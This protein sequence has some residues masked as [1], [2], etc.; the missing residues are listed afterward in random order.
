MSTISD[1]LDGQAAGEP[2]GSGGPSGPEAHDGK[3]YLNASRGVLS[4]LF[5]LDHKR[6]GV[7]STLR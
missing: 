4:W 2:K 6:I 3:N 7:M 1:T 5:T